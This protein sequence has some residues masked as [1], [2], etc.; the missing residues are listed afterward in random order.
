[1]RRIAAILAMLVVPTGAASSPSHAAIA[2]Y[3]ATDGNDRWSGKLAAP[4]DACSDGPFA[5]IAR[6]R[7]AIR[8]IKGRGALTQPVTVFLRGGIYFLSEPLVLLPRDSGTADAPITYEAYQNEKPVLSGGVAITGWRAARVNGR[9]GWATTVPDVAGGS[10]YFRQ[11]FVNDQRRPRTRLPS[12]GVHRFAGLLRP[13]RELMFDQGQDTVVFAND[14]IKAWRN[15]GDVEVIALH[16]WTEEHLP[17]ARVDPLA[18]Q[19]TFARPSRYRL[20]DGNRPN[21]ARFYVE[22]VFEALDQPGEWYLERDGTLYYLPKPAEEPARARAIAPR[23]QQVV[24]F[25][26]DADQQL[27]VEHVTLRG[28][29]FMHTEWSYSKAATSIQAAADVPAAIFWQGARNCT[30]RNCTV[31]HVGTYGIELGPGCNGNHVLLNA[32]YDLGAGAI[33]LGAG[34]SATT[35]SDNQVFAGGQVFP[36]AVG[37]WVGNSAHNEVTHNL[38]H[39]FPYTGI[40]VGWTWAYRPSPASDNHIEYNVV[41]HIGLGLLDDLGAIYTL[42]IQPG[43][44]VRNNLIHDVWSANGQA[45]GIYL[46]AGSSEMVIENNVVLR[47]DDVALM[48]NFG[49]NNQIRNNIFALGH[50]AQIKRGVAQSYRAFTVERNIIYFTDGD[51]LAGQFSDGNYAFDYNLYFNAAGRPVTFLGKSFTQWQASGQDA[52]SVVADP[53]LSGLEQGPVTVAADSPAF[54]LGFK[55]IDLSAVGPRPGGAPVP[56]Q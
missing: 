11:L 18:H 9:D 4:N 2:F 7:D 37:I 19:V 51:V 31:A 41:H 53:H 47:T 48:E 23:L 43:T 5:T 22:N 55:A 14:D 49:R 25:Q 44:T 17:I 6:A 34:S 45:R 24:R 29:S 54:S 8:E 39:R 46:D 50:Q 12:E 35:V 3:V 42:G 16:F 26:G 15:L 10:W 1:M 21:G 13:A 32:F 36:S 33:K 40:S 38:V 20:T 52:H 56:A 27:F 28:I 30:L